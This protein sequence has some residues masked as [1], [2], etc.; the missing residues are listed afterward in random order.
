MSCIIGQ[1]LRII[2]YVYIL[3]FYEVGLYVINQLLRII[4]YVHMKDRKILY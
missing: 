3:L 1:L 2:C 4:C